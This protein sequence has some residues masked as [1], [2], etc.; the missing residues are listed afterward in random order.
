MYVYSCIVAASR[1][2][3][4]DTLGHNRGSGRRYRPP[5][6]SHLTAVATNYS[7]KLPNPLISVPLIFRIFRNNRL[8]LLVDDTISFFFEPHRS[9]P[10]IITI[11]LLLLYQVSAFAVMPL[12]LFFFS[13]FFFSWLA[14]VFDAVVVEFVFFH[15]K[16]THKIYRC[17]FGGRASLILFLKLLLTIIFV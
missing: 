10:L 7:Q 17:M 9:N 13:R 15:R 11:C 2:G 12:I 14:C 5:Q 3:C 1:P 6:T 16:Y 4:S 8:L